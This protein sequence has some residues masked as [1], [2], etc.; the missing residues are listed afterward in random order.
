MVRYVWAP[1]CP[2]ELLTRQRSDGTSLGTI[3]V[4]FS[5]VARRQVLTPEENLMLVFQPPPPTAARASPGC[6]PS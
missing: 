1:S 5:P 6:A 3:D 2:A 4:T